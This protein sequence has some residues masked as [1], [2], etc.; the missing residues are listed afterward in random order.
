MFFIW[1]MSICS[2]IMCSVLPSEQAADPLLWE[3][4]YWLLAGTELWAFMVILHCSHDL[5]HTNHS[6]H[7]NCRSCKG[8]DIKPKQVS[9][10]TV[11]FLSL[12]SLLHFCWSSIIAILLH[13][14][15]AVYNYG[16]DLD[17]T[18][19]T[20]THLHLQHTNNF[21]KHFPFQTNRLMNYSMFCL[22]HFFP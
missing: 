10:R 8:Q 2:W 15:S 9:R 11:W 18:Y 5:C 17:P 3:F 13:I 1:W 22:D 21:A 12:L 16:K 7:C 20:L 6:E 19:N 14:T 4:I